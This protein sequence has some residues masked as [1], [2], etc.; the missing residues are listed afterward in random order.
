MMAMAFVSILIV[1][2]TVLVMNIQGLYRRGLSM[3]EVNST[4]RSVVDDITRAITSAPSVSATSV[5]SV[6]FRRNG[7]VE[8]GTF[9]T[10]FYSYVWKQ[11]E[12]LASNT[13]PNRRSPVQVNGNSN[14]RL[15]KASDRGRQLCDPG[16]LGMRGISSCAGTGKLICNNMSGA[17]NLA[18]TDAVELI[19]SASLEL[20]LFSFDIFPPARTGVTGQVFYAGS[21]ILGTSRGANAVAGGGIIRSETCTPP[22]DVDA[23]LDFQ[24]C[25]INKFNFAASSV[26]A[27]P[28]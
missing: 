11:A 23:L 3:R 5:H 2:I 6:E 4:A 28:E 21:F 10:G 16:Y 1:A 27:I 22:S 8:G 26:G 7:N 24:Y 12:H 20:G 9:C 13:D 17:P 15:M 18:A 19:S 14:Y 25:S